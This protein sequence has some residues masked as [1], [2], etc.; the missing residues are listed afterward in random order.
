[1]NILQV[2]AKVG[3]DPCGCGFIIAIRDPE[4]QWTTDSD[5]RPEALRRAAETAIST[6]PRR[7]TVTEC[8]K[9][10]GNRTRGFA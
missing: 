2:A 3:C 4:I 10:Q 9:Q 5:D 7:E 6:R 8:G 1:M